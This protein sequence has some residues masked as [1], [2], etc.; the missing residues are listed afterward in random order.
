[1]HSIQPKPTLSCV[2]HAPYN[3]NDMEE[4]MHFCPRPSCRMSYH[5]SCLLAGDHVDQE[6]KPPARAL[7]LLTSSPD[8]DET[9]TMSNSHPKKRSR[10]NSSTSVDRSS[11]PLALDMLQALPKKLV[12]VAQQPIVKGALFNSL[13]GNVQRVVKAR[14]L[15]YQALKDTKIDPKWKTMVNA[16]MPILQFPNIGVAFSCPKCGNAI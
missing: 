13:T 1:M 2:C 4:V 5:E 8:S 10:R 9:F 16:A 15:V 11:V 12:E 3:P 6:I 14:S 7:A